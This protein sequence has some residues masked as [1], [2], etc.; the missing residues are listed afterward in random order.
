M[1]RTSR[2]HVLQRC[3]LYFVG[4]LNISASQYC[5]I[6]ISGNARKDFGRGRRMQSHTANCQPSTP[7]CAGPIVSSVQQTAK[8]CLRIGTRPSLPKQACSRRTRREQSHRL[9]CSQPSLPNVLH[10]D[11]SN[12]L[13]SAVNFLIHQHPFPRQA[14]LEAR[15]TSDTRLTQP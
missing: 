11:N 7:H 3:Q 10:D 12:S 9:R 5:H 6:I 15:T 13:I 14:A 4:G 1:Y 8:P 2:R